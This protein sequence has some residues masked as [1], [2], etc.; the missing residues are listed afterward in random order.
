M[1]TATNIVLVTFAAFL[2]KVL[3]LSK[4]KHESRKIAQ[5]KVDVGCYLFN[6]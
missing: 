6:L 4:K 2:L 3:S 1:F 5:L